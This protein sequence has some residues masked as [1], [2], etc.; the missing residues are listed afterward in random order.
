MWIYYWLKIYLSRVRMAP[1]GD[2]NE[3]KGFSI[4]DCRDLMFEGRNEN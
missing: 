4:V 3:K 1:K 2:G